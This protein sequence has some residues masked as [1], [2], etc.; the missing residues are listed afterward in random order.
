MDKFLGVTFAENATMPAY[1]AKE[2]LRFVLNAFRHLRM[3]HAT[4]A[5]ATAE[6]ESCSTPFGIFE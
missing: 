6:K 3:N 1:G 4:A 2:R 5:A